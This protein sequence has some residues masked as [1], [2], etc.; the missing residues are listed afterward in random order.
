MRK[1]Y[2]RAAKTAKA[3]LYCVGFKIIFIGF[4][5]VDTRTGKP[6]KPL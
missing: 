1:K 6:G 5:V 2:K 4:T 3:S